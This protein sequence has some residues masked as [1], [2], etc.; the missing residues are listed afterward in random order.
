MIHL[1]AVLPGDG[2]WVA[3]LDSVNVGGTEALAGAVRAAGVQRLIHISS[4]AVY[5]DGGQPTPHRE[6]D[7]LSPNTPYAKSKLAAEQAIETVL[8]GSA[9]RW[10]VLR[11]SGLY[12]PD[13]PATAA[14]FREVSR[15]RLWLHGPARVL[16]HPT[17]VLDLVAAINRVLEQDD[18]H[19]EVINVGGER[20]VEFPEWIGL[21]GTRVGRRPAQIAAPRW[22][23]HMAAGMARGWRIIGQ[24]PARLE[25]LTRRWVNHAVDLEKARRLLGFEPVS[26]EW[27]LDQTADTLREMGLLDGG[28]ARPSATRHA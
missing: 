5:G 7:P 26:L 8:E 22:S 17:H 4:V 27:G 2:R 3:G 11:P 19:R 1:A 21:V 23:R 13:R 24:P 18:L 12:G 20:S 15:R 25:R 14:F 16:V 28:V 10:I 6:I 9:V